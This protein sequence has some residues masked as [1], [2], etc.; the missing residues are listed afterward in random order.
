MFSGVFW[1]SVQRFGTMILSFISNLVLARLLSPED[2]GTVGMLLFFVT[3]ATTFVDSGLGSALIQKA[4]LR[5]EDY[6][7][8]FTSNI[9][10]SCF[11]YAVLFFAAPW[12]AKFYGI[13]LLTILLRVEGLTLFFNAFALVQTS[14]LRKNM[15]FKKL[16]I[17]NILSNLIGTVLGI[18]LA[19]YGAGVWSL[20]GRMLVVS[21]FVALLLW[22]VSIWKPML[23]F[24]YSS[25]RELFSFGSFMLL[26]SIITAVSNNIQTLIIGR[27]LTPSILGYYT[28]AKQL[29]DVPALSISS[30]IGQVAYPVFANLKDNRLLLVDK[31]LKTV[32]IISYLNSALMVLLIVLAR[33]LILCIY[34]DAWLESVGYFQIICLG[35]IFLSIQDINYYLVAALGYS[36]VLFFC[37][38]FQ[39]LL[40][41][42]LMVGGGIMWGIEGIVYAMVICTFIFYCIYAFLSTKF[43]GISFFR[44]FSIVFGYCLFAISIGGL[45][46]LG[47]YFLGGMDILL[48]SN[49]LQ[50]VTYTLCYLILFISVSYVFRI[51]SFF[52]LFEIL[53]E[54]LRYGRS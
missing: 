50:I 30:I 21:L 49:L 11:C 37:N 6:S 45:L 31:L 53:K 12:V 35:G 27:L 23:R 24:S 54:R 43:C 52:Y 32:G 38:L 41:I 42:I 39:T 2:F 25:F 22:N 40:G 4:G 3:L 33:P 10:L 17:A 48:N 51:K 7:T 5:D 44:Q 15:E 29:R 47:G 8:V 46:F 34:G 18:L 13:P 20:V 9:I 1:S 26:S 16:A 36:R 28:Q 19:L 14:I